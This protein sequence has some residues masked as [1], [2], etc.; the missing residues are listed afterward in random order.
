MG[1]E[2]THDAVGMGRLET[3][4]MTSETG[5]PHIL[6]GVMKAHFEGMVHRQPPGVRGFRGRENTDNIIT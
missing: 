2:V 5:P 3:G 1:I 6:T 4:S